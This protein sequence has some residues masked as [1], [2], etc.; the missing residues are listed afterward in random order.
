MPEVDGVLLK[1]GMDFFADHE[2]CQQHVPTLREGSEITAS[3]V[4]LPV[5][6]G[7]AQLTTSI[8]QDGQMVYIVT[9]E[10]VISAYKRSSWKVVLFTPS[11]LLLFLLC[12]LLGIFPPNQLK[13]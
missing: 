7:N 1:C 11:M 12:E 3:V 8:L 6:M 5:A 10:Q 9:P 2:P 4:N 13:K